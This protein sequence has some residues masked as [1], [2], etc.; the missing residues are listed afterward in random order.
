MMNTIRRWLKGEGGLSEAA[1][2]IFVLPFIVTTVFLLVET[3]FNMRSRTVLDYIVTD[4]VRGVALDGGNLNPRT[5]SIGMAWSAKGLIAMRDAC[6][7]GAMRCASTPSV[8]DLTCTPQQVL[9]MTEMVSCS[10][11]IT[12][13]IVSPLSSSPIWTWGM[14]GLFTA[15]I[16][17]KISSLPATSLNG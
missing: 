8:S 17:V 11:R 2:A 16:S 1:T 7:T 13:K 4:T 9:A 3:G 12:Y 15:P 14:N 10:G 5:N 6:T